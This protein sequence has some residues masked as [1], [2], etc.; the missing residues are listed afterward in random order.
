MAGFVE[1]YHSLG[2]SIVLLLVAV[3]LGLYSRAGLA[4]AVGWGSH[5]LLDTVHVAVNGRP[6]DAA[7]LAWP[8]V[9]PPDPL[10]IPPGSFFFYYVGTPSFFVEVILWTAA[11]VVLVRDRLP[12]AVV[13]RYER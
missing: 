4:V 7:F 13:V 6:A 3:P 2:H 5:L 9:L 11:V 10:A 12:G 1:L 8:V